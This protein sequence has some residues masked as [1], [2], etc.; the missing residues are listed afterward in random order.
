MATPK[1]HR[2]SLG[3]EGRLTHHAQN[4]PIGADTEPCSASASAS[5]RHR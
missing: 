3:R 4:D 5:Q 2:P 1:H